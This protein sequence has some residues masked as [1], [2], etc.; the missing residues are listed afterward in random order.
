MRVS[1]KG[2]V[3]S[4][5][6]SR[7]HISL[8]PYPRGIWQCPSFGLSEALEYLLVHSSKNGIK[9]PHSKS[10]ALASSC[11]RVPGIMRKLRTYLAVVIFFSLALFGAAALRSQTKRGV[12]AEDY[13]SFKFIGDPHISPDG[14]SVAYVLTTIDQKKNRRDS[15]VWL[16]PA[17]GSSAPRRLSAEGFSSS[18][19]RWSP[20]G[21]T[22][23][24]VST[25]AS[26]LPTGDTPKSQIYLLSIA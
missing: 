15:S 6:L 4:R 17:D 1:S 22:L 7:M 2:N 16:V 19:P 21:K 26:D 11:A 10:L 24:I 23:A 5:L 13:L 25:R 18:S 20:D 12:T 3:V 14:K 9:L 8:G